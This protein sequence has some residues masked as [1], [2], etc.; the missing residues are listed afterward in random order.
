MKKTKREEKSNWF[1]REL[2]FV[3]GHPL[4]SQGVSKEQG[5]FGNTRAVSSE[6]VE[7]N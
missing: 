7:M 4:R 3:M 2:Q 6:G 5:E 1:T